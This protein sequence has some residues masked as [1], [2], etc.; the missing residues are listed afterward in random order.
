[1]SVGGRR[2]P[3]R[4]RRRL[5]RIAIGQPNGFR[6]DFRAASYNARQAASQATLSTQQLRR[7]KRIHFRALNKLVNRDELVRPVRD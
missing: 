2:R 3:R 7:G 6:G 4:G 5:P 1:M